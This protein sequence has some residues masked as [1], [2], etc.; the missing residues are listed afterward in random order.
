MGDLEK[1]L[2][3]NNLQDPNDINALIETADLIRELIEEE[4]YDKI[5]NV[6]KYTINKKY[7]EAFSWITDILQEEFSKKENCKLKD[8]YCNIGRSIPNYDEF[9]KRL[10]V[11]F[12]AIRSDID[13]VY[14]DTN[15][16]D[17]FFNNCSYKTKYKNIFLIT[18][19]NFDARDNDYIQYK[20][21][22]TKDLNK[23]CE[24]NIKDKKK[25]N[26]LGGKEDDRTI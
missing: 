12:N 22:F 21:V 16:I 6:I 7:F 11:D 18:S 15:D 14:D 17:S 3:K 19:E 20:L 4:Q 13:K 8:F 5:N 2:I 25:A 1:F 23:F 9:T 24:L 26:S 10:N